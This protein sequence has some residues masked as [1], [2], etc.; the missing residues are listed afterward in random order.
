MKLDCIANII[1]TRHLLPGTLVECI[2]EDGGGLLS[3][4]EKKTYTILSQEIETVRL[5][6]VLGN[7]FSTRF[8]I[9]K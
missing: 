8:K 1:A 5:Y 7:K 9:V 6:G 2:D 3:F 4:L